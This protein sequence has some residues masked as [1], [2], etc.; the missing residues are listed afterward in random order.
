MSGLIYVFTGEGKGKT[1]AA[2]WT[3]VRASLR[4]MRVAAIQWYKEAVWPTAE[5]EIGKK[6]KLGNEILDWIGIY[7]TRINANVLRSVF[8]GFAEENIIT[9]PV[10]K[11]KSGKKVIICAGWKPGWSTDYDAVLL[12]KNFKT[13]AIVNMTN[14]DYVYSKDPKKYK[15]AKPVREIS[16]K[17]FRKLGGNKWKPGLNRP[18]DPI[19]AKEAEKSNLKVIVI[20]NDLGNLK[21]LLSNK[22]FKGT[23]IR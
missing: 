11:I 18:F 12:A 6:L 19:A 17:N 4:G 23:I 7:A 13:D 14:I 16:W 10:K 3:G 9:D 21:N 20:G 15:S 5:Q 22:Q 2:F 1:S 8:R